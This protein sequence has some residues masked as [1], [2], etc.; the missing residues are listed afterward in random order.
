ML[1]FIR[2]DHKLP[3]RLTTSMSLTAEQVH[4]MFKLFDST[5]NNGLYV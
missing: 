1:K 2:P 4:Q 3:E 5:N